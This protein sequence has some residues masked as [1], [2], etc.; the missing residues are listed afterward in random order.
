MWVVAAMDKKFIVPPFNCQLVV[1]RGFAEH[2]SRSKCKV[3]DLKQC[4]SAPRVCTPC[5][6]RSFRWHLRIQMHGAIQPKTSYFVGYDARDYKH[7]LLASQRVGRP[8]T[9]RRNIIKNNQVIGWGLLYL[10][11]DNDI[12]SR[13]PFIATEAERGEVA[14][15]LWH[16]WVFL[17]RSISVTNSRRRMVQKQKILIFGHRIHFWGDPTRPGPTGTLFRGLLLE[18]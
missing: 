9:R 1:I 18:N 5:G 7:Q 15:F 2:C 10:I 12:G 14:L 11:H 13:A 17:R 6:R 8:Y 3:W 4:P 16:I